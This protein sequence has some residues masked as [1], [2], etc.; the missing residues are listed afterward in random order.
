MAAN[1]LES[2]GVDVAIFGATPGAALLAGALASEHGL[3]V[4]LIGEGYSALRL[5]RGLNLAIGMWTRP[6]TWALLGGLEADLA[7]LLGKAGINDAEETI[8]VAFAADL[9]ATREA[10]DHVQHLALGYGH[11]VAR[12]RGGD[13]LTIHDVALLEE[14]R[15]Y[16]RLNAWLD[17][18]GVLRIA[19]DVSLNLQKTGKAAIEGKSHALSAKKVVLADGPALIPELNDERGPETLRAVDGSAIL[20]SASRSARPVVRQFLDRGTTVSTHGD[21]LLVHIAGS[22][23]REARLGASLDGHLPLVRVATRRLRKV[24][25]RDGAPLVGWLKVPRVFIV[26]GLGDAAAFYAPAI[27]RLIAG[28]P[29]PEE[30]SWFA[31]RDPSRLDGRETIAEFVAGDFA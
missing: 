22:E 5:P 16:P 23:N 17:S 28:N 7:A 8:D 1:P 13:E 10:L 6:E 19:G 3:S 29:Q 31:A 25:T 12:S 21:G 30:K 2:G 20:T 14:T 24:V 27:A 18:L 9:P 15:L 26:A 11:K 4:A